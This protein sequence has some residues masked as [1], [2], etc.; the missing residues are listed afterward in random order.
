[1]HKVD[2][3]PQLRLAAFKKL[4]RHYISAE[5]AVNEFSTIMITG[6]YWREAQ[7]DRLVSRARERLLNFIA[8][9]RFRC[10]GVDRAVRPVLIIPDECGCVDLMLECVLWVDPA[11]GTPMII[12]DPEGA[13]PTE[14][15]FNAK[16]WLTNRQGVRRPD[17]AA[18]VTRAADRID[19]LVEELWSD[20][21]V[22]AWAAGPPGP[23]LVTP[24]YW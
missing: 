17:L 15:S 19:G 23:P 11:D 13:A 21:E 4:F 20:P 24:A 3:L 22:M 2:M 9:D 16:G 7:L 1:M 14:F 12:C 5:T 6:D 8:L 18:G 10:A